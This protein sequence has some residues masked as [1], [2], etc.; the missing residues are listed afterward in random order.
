MLYHNILHKSIDPTIITLLVGIF[1]LQVLS[2][3]LKTSYIPEF[4][5][6]CKMNEDKACKKDVEDK[7]NKL[8]FMFGF[9]KYPFTLSEAL[10]KL[11]AMSQYTKFMSHYF[12]FYPDKRMVITNLIISKLDGF[13]SWV[14]PYVVVAVIWLLLYF[15]AIIVKT[16]CTNYFIAIYEHKWSN[17]IKKLN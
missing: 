1:L 3:V 15:C 2:C 5:F 11:G 7:K 14:S 12:P 13:L 4:H 16:L 10:Y 6:N 17:V 8:A 9:T